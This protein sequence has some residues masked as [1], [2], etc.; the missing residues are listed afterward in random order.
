MTID[1]LPEVRAVKRAA[2]AE[3]RALYEWAK[4]KAAEDEQWLTEHPGEEAAYEERV[5]VS[6]DEMRANSA[7][8]LARWEE[9]ADTPPAA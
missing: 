3:L 2:I 7:V 4:A 1:E 6:L 8:L 9:R 5:G